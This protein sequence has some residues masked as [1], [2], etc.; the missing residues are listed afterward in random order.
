MA[1]FHVYGLDRLDIELEQLAA[2]DDADALLILERGGEVYKA[3]HQRYLN[4]WHHL[5]GQLEASISI[6]QKMLT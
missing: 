2:V 6:V 5:T 4:A 1:G 3:A